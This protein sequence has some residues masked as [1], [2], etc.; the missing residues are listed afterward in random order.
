MKICM[1]Q[2]EN[3]KKVGIFRREFVIDVQKV[4]NVMSQ[5]SNGENYSLL[6]ITEFIENFEDFKSIIEKAEKIFGGEY[7]NL[8]AEKKFKLLAPTSRENKIICLGK[9]YKEHAKEIGDDA[10]SE[11]ILFGKFADC[12]IGHDE[13]IIYPPFA[14]RVDPE[15]ELGVIIGKAGKNIPEE[16]VENYIF[17]Y[18]IANDITEREMEFEDMKKGCPWFRSKNFDTFMSIGPYIVT[19]DKISEPHNLHIELRVNSEKRQSGNTQDMIFNIPSHI[20]YISKY[21]KLYPGDIISTGTVSG[22]KPVIKGD[23]IEAEIE[24]IGILRNYVI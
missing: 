17:G 4:I 18:T 15:V 21:I 9:N 2:K 1:Y 13:S 5:I 3:I 14:K 12:A 10:P 23:I 16:E 22:I 19:K 6:R 7:K 11:P 24:K 20:S 8:F